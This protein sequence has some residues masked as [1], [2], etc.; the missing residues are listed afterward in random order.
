M[1][2]GERLTYRIDVPQA[3]ED[4]PVPKLIVQPI[5]EN[6]AVYGMKR[7]DRL[8]IGLSA[9]CEG[10]EVVLRVTDNGP[11]IEPEM[12]RQLK[13]CLADASAER[14]D[15]F[16]IMNVH[17][18]IR[19]IYGDRYGISIVSQVGQGTTVLLHF[20]QDSARKGDLS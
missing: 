10:D 19:L 17:E 2:F 1:R 4:F 8:F 5:I 15:H 12:L 20:P 16:G 6:A 18:R 3:L 11:G 13:S 9:Y 7:S 14:G